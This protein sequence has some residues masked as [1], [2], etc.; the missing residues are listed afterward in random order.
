MHDEI[1]FED[2]GNR[3]RYV[4]Q[5]E[6]AE[7]EMTVSKMSSHLWIVDHTGVPE[8]LNGQGIGKKLALYVVEDARKAGRT[9]RAT[10]PFFLAQAARHP[11]WSDVVKI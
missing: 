6:G 7:A 9:L 2:G 3:G 11:E 1:T 4:L 10:C 8:S 5:K